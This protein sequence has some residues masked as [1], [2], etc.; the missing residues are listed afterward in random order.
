MTQ[1]ST[2]T[3]LNPIHH[4]PT[5]AAVLAPSVGAHASPTGFD[6]DLI[7]RYDRPGP[8]YT[9][10]PTALQFH[11]RF[12]ETDYRSALARSHA[13]HTPLSLYVHIPFCINPCF[14]CACTK[15][16]TRQTAMADDYLRRLYREI[17]MQGQAVPRSREVRQLHLG[18]GTPT[19]LSTAQLRELVET[20]GRH[21][22]LYR[23][24]DRE[25]SI[26]IDPRSVKPADMQE[27]VDIG[28]NRISLGIQDFDTRVQAAVNR[29]Q[30]PAQVFALVEAARTAG[31]ESISMDLIYGLPL[32]TPESFERTLDL[33]IQANPERISAYSYAHLPERFKPQRQIHTEQLPDARTKLALLELTVRHLTK[34]GYVY[35]GMDHFARADDPLAQAQHDSSMQRNF[36]GYSTH[37]GLDM[38][39]LGMSS[40]GR[41]DDCYAQNARTIADY[42]AA[43]DSGHLAIDRGLRL[44]AEDR[45]RRDVIE[46]IM[47]AGHLPL[48]AIERK[49]GIRF[50]SH[51]ANELESLIPLEADGLVE[52]GIHDIRV[53]DAGRFLLRAVA[54]CFDA[55]TP[56]LHQQRPAHSRLI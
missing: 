54:M 53:T 37:A 27:L 29:E 35:I 8:R 56:K 24:A 19:F 23:G 40:I 20:I 31:I 5:N 42:Y 26:E 18:G 55:Y 9:S 12:S 47:C 34:A 16:I 22:S 44:S 36:Q 17:E 3:S 30:S 6:A 14:Y 7:R 52:I 21:F 28:F 50:T 45:L 48:P 51:F 13:S 49:H 11:E 46:S 38:I 33:V 32:Q 1:S 43:I 41:I 15:V 39:G 4:T 25:F 2:P 10:Y